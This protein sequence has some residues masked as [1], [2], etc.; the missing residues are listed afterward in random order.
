MEHYI[1]KKRRPSKAHKVW[2][3]VKTIAALRIIVMIGFS[4]RDK[5]GNLMSLPS[6]IILSIRL[7]SP[8]L[9]LY[10]F[11]GFSSNSYQILGEFASHIL[12]K[13]K[14]SYKIG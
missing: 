1:F 2:V 3:K 10:F 4:N 6:I 9:L 12:T 8:V 7:N 13:L 14:L 11:F 5:N